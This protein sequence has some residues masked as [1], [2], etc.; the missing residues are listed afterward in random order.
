MTC[1][2]LMDHS[3]RHP[4]RSDTFAPN[5]ETVSKRAIKMAWWQQPVRND[6]KPSLQGD[7][8]QE[9]SRVA[10]LMAEWQGGNDLAGDSLFQEL[11]GELQEIARLKLAREFNSS[12]STGDLI[13]EAVIRLSKMRKINVQ[14]REHVLALAARIM[15]QILIDQARKRNADKRYH[16]KVTLVTG[17]VDTN[18]N[19][20]VLSLDLILQ[21]LREIDPQR[22]DI[23]EMRYFGGMSVEEVAVVLGISKN[24]IWRRW[25]ATRLWLQA[26]LES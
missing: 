22:A 21:E 17:L 19:F 14:G 26:R 25:A 11:L 10:G 13:N 3:Y 24:T 2:I 6:N 20:D 12:L 8:M 23:V 9:E 5:L 4:N 15:K 1:R 18:E 16:T 7:G